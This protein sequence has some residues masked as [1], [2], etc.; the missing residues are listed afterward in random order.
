MSERDFSDFDEREVVEHLDREADRKGSLF[1]LTACLA[2][3]AGP[4]L[5]ALLVFA[6]G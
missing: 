1:A 2:V 5:S 4:A 3:A 6:G